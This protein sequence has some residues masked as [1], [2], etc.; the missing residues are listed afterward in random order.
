[1]GEGDDV[2]VE[3]WEGGSEPFST[4][5]SS[6]PLWP[7][8][9]RMEDRGC[10]EVQ[11]IGGAGGI[12]SCEERERLAAN[13]PWVGGV[14]GEERV[15]AQFNVSLVFAI[16]TVNP[17]LPKGFPHGSFQPRQNLTFP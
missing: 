11:E 13:G 3:C 9:R 12:R 16:L 8:L 5:S 4:S 7:R 6:L 15:V 14:G 10:I 2:A 1:M 17:L